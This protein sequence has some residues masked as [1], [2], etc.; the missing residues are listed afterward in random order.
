MNTLSVCLIEV[1]F[2][3]LLLLISDIATKEK[4]RLINFTTELVVYKKFDLA[5]QI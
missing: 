2:I 5:L 1:I 4:N 3:N